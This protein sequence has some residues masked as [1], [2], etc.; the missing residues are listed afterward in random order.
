MEEEE[1]FTLDLH[2]LGPLGMWDESHPEELCGFRSSLLRAG[3]QASPCPSVCSTDLA[4][5]FGSSQCS[6][7]Q[8][9]LLGFTLKTGGCTQGLFI[10]NPWCGFTAAGGWV[11]YQDH[12]LLCTVHALEFSCR[13]IQLPCLCCSCL[14]NT[15]WGSRRDEHFLYCMQYIQITG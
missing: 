8:C 9:H 11:P 4:L 3:V 15:I 10:P 5:P 14:P 12:C 1:S 13:D 7:N 6:Q 2:D